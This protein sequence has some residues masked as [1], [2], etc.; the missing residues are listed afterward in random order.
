MLHNETGDSGSILALY[1]DGKIVFDEKDPR[2]SEIVF[3][4]TIAFIGVNRL[5]EA[6]ELV[7]RYYPVPSDKNP[8]V[9]NLHAKMCQAEERVDEAIGYFEKAESYFAGQQVGIEA[10]WNK[11]LLRY[12]T[13]D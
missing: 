4:V 8:N 2:L 6:R 1:D 5:V 10:R 13:G 7:D 11:S 9:I 12:R 3:S